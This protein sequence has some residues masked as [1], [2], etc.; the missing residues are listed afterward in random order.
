MRTNVDIAEDV[1]QAVE[2]RARR[3][4]R[5]AGEV[6]TDLARQAMAQSSPAVDAAEDAEAPF[7]GFHPFPRRGVTITNE[8]ID[9]LREE[10]GD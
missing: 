5:S 6:L 9:R 8:L 3:E 1:L 2:D 4:R 7:F 10:S